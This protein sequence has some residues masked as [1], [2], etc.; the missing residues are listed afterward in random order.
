LRT[1]RARG[2]T[3]RSM[4]WEARRPSRRSRAPTEIG[5]SYATWG[6]EIGRLDERS[7]WGAARV[8]R[9]RRLSLGSGTRGRAPVY[10]GCSLALPRLSAPPARSPTWGSDP[11]PDTVSRTAG[12]SHGRAAGAVRFPVPVSRHAEVTPAE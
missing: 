9:G 1:S 8:P 6:R 2:T 12:D 7:S 4:A 11:Q 10:S 5:P 3:G